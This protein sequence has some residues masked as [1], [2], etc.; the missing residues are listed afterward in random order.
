M[1]IPLA[2]TKASDEAFKGA[3]VLKRTEFAKEAQTSL[4]V[5]REEF[6]EEHTSEPGGEHFDVDEEVIPRGNPSVAIE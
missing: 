4:A 5:E 3:G 2:V 6:I 1:D